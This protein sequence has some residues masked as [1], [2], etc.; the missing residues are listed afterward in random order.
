LALQNFGP[1]GF[2]PV[3]VPPSELFLDVAPGLE[4]LEGLDD[5]KVGHLLKLGMLG[6]VRVLHRDDDSL[7]EEVL[8]DGDQVL[9]GHQHLEAC[10]ARV[11]VRLS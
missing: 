11:K 4:G 10:N 8:V 1:E 3:V 7:G 5:V 6:C 9:L 2:S